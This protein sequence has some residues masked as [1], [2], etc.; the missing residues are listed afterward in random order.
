MGALLTFAFSPLGR[1]V[2]IGLA[3]LAVAGGLYLKIYSDGAASERAKQAR[4]SLNNLRN[5][6]ET[7]ATVEKLPPTDIDNELNR[8]MLPDDR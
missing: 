2:V 6:T 5:R 1:W 8:W 3:G 4:E 7:N